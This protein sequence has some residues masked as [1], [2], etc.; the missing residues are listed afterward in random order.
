M[1]GNGLYCKVKVSENLFYKQIF[2][3]IVLFRLS[4]IVKETGHLK[5]RLP[6]NHFDANKITQKDFK[7]LK[8]NINK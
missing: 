1:E 8:V 3:H 7:S 2:K 4:I 6:I 5:F